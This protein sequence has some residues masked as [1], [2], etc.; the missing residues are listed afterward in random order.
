MKITRLD[1]QTRDSTADS[2]TLSRACRRLVIG[3]A[4][5]ADIRLESPA[6]SPQHAELSWQGGF[7]TI[8]DL[9]SING[10]ALRGSR[11]LRGVLQDQD[12]FSAGGIPFRADIEP[13]DRAARRTRLLTVTGIAL[14]AVA[15]AILVLGFFLDA[16]T[17]APEAPPQDPVP[18][19]PPVSDPAFQKMSD[20]YAQASLLFDEARRLIADGANDLS[21]AR[22]LAQ[23]IALNPNLPQAELLLN[24]LQKSHGS[25]I[26]KQI[27][28]LVAAGRFQEALDNLE[29]QKALLGAP[30]AIR[31]TQTVISQNMKLQAAMEFLEQGD[32][33]TAAE[34]L[35]ALSDDLIPQKKSA[36]DRLSKCRAASAWAE[37]LVDQADQNDL[38]AVERLARQEPAHSPYLSEDALDEVRSALA[39]LHALANLQKLVDAGN[40]YILVRYLP[41]VPA[42][43]DMLKPLRKTLAP[44]AAEFRQT[45]E[46]QAAQ[47]GTARAPADLP[48]AL[49]S[50]N[51]AKAFAALCIIQEN[52]N[53]LR[54]YRRHAGRWTAYLAA[55][56][57]RAKDY[58]DKGAREEARAILTPLLPHLDDYDAE[59]YPVRNR[60]AQIVPVSFSP[61]TAHLLDKPADTSAPAE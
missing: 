39:R 46:T 41:E 19:L 26:Q 38:P 56:A 15:L 59:T 60:M 4:A 28:A 25:G 5:P 30:A 27:D 7:V 50:Y 16:K 57:A 35:D 51:A 52:D 29:N 42:L 3:R 1:P 36:L 48:D 61:E 47:T 9:A 49:A 18:I 31:K 24:G 23:A 32:L 12:V 53:D 21:A 55:S 33:D 11:I 34:I 37:E 45:A 20:Q 13:S 44:Q 8:R 6:I 54:Q 22:L 10:I 40:A 2:W 17:T 14:G 43:A 58:I